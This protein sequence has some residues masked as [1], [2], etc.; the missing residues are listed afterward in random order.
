MDYRGKDLA[1]V[2]KDIDT[3]Y[4]HYGLL[5]RM[6]RVLALAKKGFSQSDVEYGLRYFANMC[7]N[8]SIRKVLLDSYGVKR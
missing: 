4:N 8:K 7:D 1:T 2:I 6:D 3:S 5:T